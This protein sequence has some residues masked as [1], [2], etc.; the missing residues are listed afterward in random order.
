[1][2]ALLEVQ[3]LR[4]SYVARD[5]QRS[6]A[7]AQVNFAL[8]RGEILGVLGESGSGKSTLAAALLRVLPRNAEIETGSV[9]FEGRDLLRLESSAMREARGARLAMIFQEPSLAL[10]PTIRVS[11]QVEDVLA[12]HG[13]GNRR[14][15]RE[16]AK[17]VL[18]AV[19]PA[20]TERIAKAFPHQLSGGQRARV[21]IAQAICC[22]PSL[23]VADEPTASLDPAVR[24]EILSL[25]RKLQEQFELSLI[26]I[27]HDPSLVA[28]FADR[29]MV[30][31]GG[32]VVEIGATEAVLV[33]PRHPYSQALLSCLPPEVSGD[34]SQHKQKLPVIG[35]D[36]REIGFAVRR[37]VFEARCVDR[38]NVC[39]EREP[40]MVELPGAHKVSCFRYEG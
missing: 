29:V 17:Q 22:G 30:L 8:Q 11:A 9:G 13:W 34:F 15:R 4:V 31:Y 28:G 26:W 24:Q 12:A 33:S 25:F 21:L 38:M 2:T 6:T 39:M 20:E 16:R 7:L 18:A 23:I 27:T 35:G 40:E 5:G 14:E 37:C 36:V 32:R 19:F 1:M 3:D 10:H